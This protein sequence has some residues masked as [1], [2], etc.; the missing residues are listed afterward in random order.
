MNRWDHPTFTY[1]VFAPA[2]TSTV[3]PSDIFPFTSMYL[4]VFAWGSLMLMQESAQYS[5]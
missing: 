1:Q 2:F 4:P 3:S 5:A